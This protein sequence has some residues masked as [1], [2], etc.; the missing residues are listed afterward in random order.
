MN[1]LRPLALLLAS[2]SACSAA[3]IDADAV[4][5][6]DSPFS[7]ADIEIVDGA[8]GPTT[9]RL[10]DGGVITDFLV[11]GDSS[12]VIEGGNVTSVGV[13]TDNASLIVRGGSV[14]CTDPFCELDIVAELWARDQSRIE[15]NGGSIGRLYEDFG[16]AYYYIRLSG[17]STLTVWG[18]DFSV[19]S[20]STGGLHEISGILSDGTLIDLIV[21]T[22]DLSGDVFLVPEPATL[23][24]C[25]ATFVILSHCLLRR[26]S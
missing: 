21:L 15:I 5:D 1:F 12:F 8:G 7:G 18:S 4:I 17:A 16:I 19:S 10:V 2:A 26:L 3:V 6:G 20:S 23:A 25:I 9:A 13:L 22:S 14:E 24:S 11:Q